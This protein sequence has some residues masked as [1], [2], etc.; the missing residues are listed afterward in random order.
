MKKECIKMPEEI[1]GYL[2]SVLAE[3]GIEP[4]TSE[5]LDDLRQSLYVELDRYTWIKL[6]EHMPI[7]HLEEFVQMNEDNKS[8][9]EKEQFVA[10]HI[11][12]AVQIYTDSFWEFKKLYI[13]QVAQA[14]NATEE[15]DI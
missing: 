14:K 9:Q 11:P 15:G 6:A 8:S 1:K 5:S 2:D 12:K 3:A 4:L 13:Q 7:E 10:Q